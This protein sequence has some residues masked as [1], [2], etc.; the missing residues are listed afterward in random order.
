LYRPGGERS[1]LRFREAN[2]VPT[3][4]LMVVSNHGFG[5]DF[6]G[7]LQLVEHWPLDLGMVAGAWAGLVL[8]LLE[9]KHMPG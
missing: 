8:Q 2:A 4:N 5:I 7:R 1:P 9:M 6:M 3:Q